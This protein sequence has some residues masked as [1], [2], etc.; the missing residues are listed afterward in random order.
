MTSKPARFAA[1][2]SL[3]APEQL[4]GDALAPCGL[5]GQLG[6]GGKHLGEQDNVCSVLDFS[7]VLSTVKTSPATLDKRKSP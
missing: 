6:L 1:S 3:G 5:E 4:L 2:Q 7:F